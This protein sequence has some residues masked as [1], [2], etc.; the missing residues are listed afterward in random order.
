MSGVVPISEQAK[1][2]A[3]FV[4][5]HRE[6]APYVPRDDYPHGIWAPESSPSESAEELAEAM[7][8]DVGFQ[9]VQ[10]GGFLKTPNGKLI[11]E[12]VGLALSPADRPVFNLAV[13]ALTLAAEKQQT[14][15]P[16]QVG[17]GVV[18]AAL[19]LWLL[20]SADRPG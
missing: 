17:V 3:A 19:V 10:L 12:G 5:N 11:A 20:S 2:I 9:A 14:I 15:S 4:A 16:K 13:D 7:V 6:F 1:Q 18:C 8:E